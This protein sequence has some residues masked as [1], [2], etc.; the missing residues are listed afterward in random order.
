M[1]DDDPGDLVHD[2]FSLALHGDTPIGR[3]ILGSVE[4]ITAL[5]RRK[6]H[7]YYTRRY[8]AP[9]MVEAARTAL[10]DRATVIQS[11]LTELTLE[12]PVDVTFSNAVFHWVSD[13]D[14]LFS[15]LH[16]AMRPGARLVAQCGGEGNVAHFLETVDE[17]VADSRFTKYFEGWRNP[18][19]FADPDTTAERLNRAGF[20]EVE[21]WLEPWP[22]RPSEPREFMRTV[23]LG[24]H[25]P[26]VPPELRDTFTDVVAGRAGPELDYVRLNINARRG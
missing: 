1:R 25:L 10:G 11:D 19:N 24:D 20:D 23:C 22:V 5:T 18:W 17:V 4:S 21:T 12:G 14:R 16:G 2:E 3:P 8:S 26:R 6:I 7:G 13:H 15:A 9:S